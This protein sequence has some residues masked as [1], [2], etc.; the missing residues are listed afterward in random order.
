LLVGRTLSKAAKV[1]GVPLFLWVVVISSV[2][3]VA[4][5]SVTQL[6][7]RQSRISQQSYEASLFTVLVTRTV[8]RKSA[9]SV[10]VQVRNRDAHQHSAIVTVACYTVN[11]DLLEEQSQLTGEVNGETSVTLPYN[12]R[13]DRSAFS[14]CDIVVED[15]T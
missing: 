11:G 6:S 3:G 8:P 4:A 13:I 14:Y 10:D 15:L 9:V 5:F 12:F 7:S 1:L 2:V